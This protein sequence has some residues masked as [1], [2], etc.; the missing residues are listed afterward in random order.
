MKKFKYKFLDYYEGKIST[1]IIEVEAEGWELDLNGHLHFK[2]KDVVIHF[3]MVDY[4]Q[5]VE[6]A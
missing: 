6:D 3:C 5:S 1:K 2:I 4:W